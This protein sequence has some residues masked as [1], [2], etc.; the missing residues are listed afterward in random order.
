MTEKINTSVTSVMLPLGLFLIF[1]AHR[2]ARKSFMPHTQSGAMGGGP[3]VFLSKGPQ[4][5]VMS[6][7]GRHSGKYEF[8]AANSI[9]I[10]YYIYWSDAYILLKCPT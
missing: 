7:A 3:K 1:T 4:N 6:L 10:L 9:D 8:P 2:K 5:Y